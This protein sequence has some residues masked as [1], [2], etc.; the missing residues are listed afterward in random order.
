M[1]PIFRFIYLVLL[2]LAF[3]ISIIGLFLF[4]VVILFSVLKWVLTG[5]GINPFILV[6]TPPIFVED[7]AVRYLGVDPIL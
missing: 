2:L 4:P 6:F 5:K 3:C 1:A 7:M